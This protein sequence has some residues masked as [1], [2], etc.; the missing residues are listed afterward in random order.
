MMATMTAAVSGDR[1]EVEGVESFVG[2]DNGCAAAEDLV[3]EIGAMVRMLVVESQD[4]ANPS[5]V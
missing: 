1:G 5:T 2:P 4:V 3:D